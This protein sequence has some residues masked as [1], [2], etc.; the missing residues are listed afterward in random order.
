M[1]HCSWSLNVVARGM[2][3]SG[4]RAITSQ[5]Y[6]VEWSRSWLTLLTVAL[7]NIYILFQLRVHDR[8]ALT[9]MV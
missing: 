1:A 6:V 9:I 3:F 4:A 2:A 8:F 5:S 7:F